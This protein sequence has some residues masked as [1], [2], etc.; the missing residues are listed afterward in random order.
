MKYTNQTYLINVKTFTP[1]RYQYEVCSTTR[2][3]S[4]LTFPRSLIATPWQIATP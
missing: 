1:K 4:A 3:R 2:S